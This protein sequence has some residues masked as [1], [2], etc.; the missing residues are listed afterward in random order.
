MKHLI[1]QVLWK[2]G[3]DIQRV[4]GAGQTGL[5]ACRNSLDGVLGQ[6]RR[7]GVTPGTGIDVGAAFGIFTKECRKI[8]LDAHFVLG[9]SI[10]ECLPALNKV[11]NAIPHATNVATVVAAEYG[12][13]FLN[14]HH[15][16]VGLSLYREVEEVR[17]SM[18][19][20]EKFA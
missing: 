19:F 11:A 1:R 17:T 2:L 5:G 3:F 6:V 7:V 12:P 20:G 14:G 10:D 8:F 9:E 4:N 16:F 18:V 15:D 13:I